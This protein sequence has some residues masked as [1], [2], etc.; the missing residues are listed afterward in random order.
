MTSS[1]SFT[2]LTRERTNPSPKGW[3]QE[4][5]RDTAGQAETPNTRAGQ[6]ELHQN[7]CA[8]SPQTLQMHVQQLTLSHRETLS[9]E[10]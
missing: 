1:Q 8:I 5:W 4:I 3:C 2:L 6:A 7:S 9:S 10:P